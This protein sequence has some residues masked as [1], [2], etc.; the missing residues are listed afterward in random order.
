MA[1]IRLVAV[2]IVAVFAIPMALAADDT[3]LLKE[4]QKVFQ[5]LPKDTAIPESPI[6]AERAHLGR[7]LFFDPRLSVDGNVSCATC[8][9]PALYGSDALRKSIGVRQRV[10]ARNAPTVLNTALSFVNN[11]RGD[12]ESVEH[13]AV[14]A[15]TAA[16]SSGQPDE[17]AVIAQLE[18]IPGYA[19]LFEAAFPNEP[20]PMTVSNI[21]KAI[22]AYERTLVTPSPFD[23]YLGGKVDALSPRERVGLEKFI[24]TG[25]ATC[26][27]GVGIGGSLYRKF[28]V[29]A[30]YWT[31]TGSRDV[32]KG[33][34]DVTND[35]VDMYVFRVPSLRNVAMTPPYFHDGAVASLPEAVRIMANIQLGTIL[36][37]ED[38]R[39]IVAFLGS[40]TGKLPEQ[41]VNAPILPPAALDF[42]DA[43]SQPK[44]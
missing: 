9:Q 20:R 38:T 3:A 43:T 7:L 14:R 12:R 36:S 40:L 29:V 31:A 27:N 5:P 34:F 8:H 42:A 18:R 26:H 37:E 2:T 24:S 1:N 4:A 35:P 6:T 23:A 21:A 32:D 15:L 28:G 44:N 33:R 19:P 25:C 16:G 30:D 10:Q 41:F 13:Q 17:R 22:G 11:W 39:D